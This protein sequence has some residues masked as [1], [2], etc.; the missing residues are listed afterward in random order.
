LRIV[1]FL[2]SIADAILIP[3]VVFVLA[4]DHLITA[5][6]I[7]GGFSMINTVLNARILRQIVK[8]RKHARESVAELQG[9]AVEAEEAAVEA[10]GIAASEAAEGQRVTREEGEETRKEVRRSANPP[11]E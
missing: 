5:A 10:K 7:A 4:L 11:R 3:A 1:Q 6:I 2:T 8:T 9:M